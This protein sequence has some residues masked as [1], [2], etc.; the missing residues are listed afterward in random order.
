M[1]YLLLE[2]F[3]SH[4]FTNYIMSKLVKLCYSL[5]PFLAILFTVYGWRNSFQWS[6]CVL[7]TGI[8]VLMSIGLMSLL[9]GCLVLVTQPYEF[10]FQWKATFGAGGEIFE[11][12]RKPSVD[13]YLKVYL[14]NVT[15]HQAYMSRKEVK[16]KLQQIGP[17][18]YKWVPN[19][20]WYLH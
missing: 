1:H 5:N 14:F 16:L 10:I 9:A 8:F 13:L 17:Y 15:N 7:L 2:H 18:V 6:F 20:I 12:W 11:I 4:Y 3:S 19:F